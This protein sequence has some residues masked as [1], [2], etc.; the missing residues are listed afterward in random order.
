MISSAA[1]ARLNLSMMDVLLAMDGLK[2]SDLRVQL[3]L[4][5]LAS[6][7]SIKSRLRAVR[8]VH[9]GHKPKAENANLFEW[10]ATCWM[11]ENTPP[12]PPIGNLV[13]LKI[14]GRIIHIAIKALCKAAPRAWK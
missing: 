10:S 3:H 8:L 6:R 7:P 11:T 5:F 12:K 9:P 1:T 4:N 13:D 14:S 2:T